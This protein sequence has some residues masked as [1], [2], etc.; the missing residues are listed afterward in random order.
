MTAWGAAKIARVEENL[1]VVRDH[2]GTNIAEA[3]RIAV[4]L[5]AQAIRENKA[6]P[7]VTPLSSTPRPRRLSSSRRSG[8][9]VRSSRAS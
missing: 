2:F 3:F 4:H 5:A 9:K 7:D 6:L 1:A 8:S